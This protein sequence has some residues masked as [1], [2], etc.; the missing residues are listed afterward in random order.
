VPRRPVRLRRDGFEPVLGAGFTP[1]TTRCPVRPE[2]WFDHQSACIRPSRVLVKAR[3]TIP[4][5]RGQTFDV[6]II[7]LILVG[8]ICATPAVLLADGPIIFGV[9]SASVTVAIAL[10]PWTR[11]GEADFLLS[12]LRPMAVF[13]AIPAVWIFIQT[14]PLASIGLAHPIW[15]SAAAALG[16]PIDGSISIDTGASF[17]TLARY[18]A[19]FAVF[20]SSV[21]VA[22]DRGRAVWILRALMFT[23]TLIA[24]TVISRN[25][26]GLSFVFDGAV[27]TGRIEATNC[28]ALGIIF[29]IA[30]A[31]RNI[32][33]YPGE[34]NRPNG[35]KA[36]LWSLLPSL[37]AFILCLLAIA[38]T[39]T[40][41]AIVAAAFGTATL[42]AVVVIRHLNV[43][44]WGITA[45]AATF[46]V[47]LIGVIASQP[48]I[49]T[50][51]AT[52][53]FAG[54]TSGALASV[55]QRILSDNPW[56]GIGAGTFAA[57]APVYRDATDSSTYTTGP[58]AAATT[59]IELGR[60]MFWAIVCATL[61][62]ILAL[63][64][65]ALRR[66]RDSFYAACGAGCLVA[67]LVIAFCNAGIYGTAISIIVAAAVGLA[68]GQSRSRVVP[69]PRP[70]TAAQPS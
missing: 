38:T 30:D 13:A 8:L 66:G 2:G 19:M 3:R 1:L 63:L 34:R 32:E 17:M 44:P 53:A 15:Q 69:P 23:T 4:L 37:T 9:V 14:L 36:P 40:S 54:E 33:L 65:G 29:A 41:S 25:V 20:V 70:R 39:A 11:R 27:S 50:V 12:I 46:V 51:D 42:M 60:F 59:V 10:L 43:G 67:L 18:L 22:I 49:R 64:R 57:I 56:T 61:V 31:I 24:I 6:S 62:A 45:I 52:L 58:T 68:F 35:P 7:R 48:L 55:T 5:G 28:A 47:A 21:A 16:H 26:F